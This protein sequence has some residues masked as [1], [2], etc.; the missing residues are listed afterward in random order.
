MD[1]TLLLVSSAQMSPYRTINIGNSA[2][3]LVKD[4]KGDTS[5]IGTWHKSFMTPEGYKVGMSLQRVKK[6]YRDNLLKEPGWGYYIELPSKWN[7][8]FVVGQTA[9]EHVPV[10]TTKVTYI[11][12]R[13]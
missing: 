6:E 7:L 9:T 5:F 8:Q 13:H 10:D 4:S 3:Q 12:K 1:D 11:F 2:F